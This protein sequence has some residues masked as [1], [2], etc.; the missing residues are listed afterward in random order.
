MRR[1]IVMATALAA[2]AIVPA[3]TVGAQRCTQR[4]T[5]RTAQYKAVAT[6][7]HVPVTR[8]LG[9]GALFG[10]TVTRGSARQGAVRRV[11]VY[12]VRGVRSR[13]AVAVR[14]ERPALFLSSTTPTAAER[15]VLDRLRGR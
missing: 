1:A 9:R 8:R 15:R 4:L 12:A 6:R 5:Y 14:P 13:V 7:A 11:R 10:C 2:I 3:T